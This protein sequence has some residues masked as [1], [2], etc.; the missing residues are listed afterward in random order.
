M[1]TSHQIE[2]VGR[3]VVNTLI[4]RLWYL[5]PY[6]DKQ[7]DRIVKIHAIFTQLTG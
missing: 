1:F 4:N 2:Y 6:I 3:D 7:K 5:D